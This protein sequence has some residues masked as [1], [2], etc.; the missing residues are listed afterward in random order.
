MLSSARLL[1]A[2]GTGAIRPL[3]DKG[4]TGRREKVCALRARMSTFGQVIGLSSGGSRLR[5]ISYVAKR[6]YDANSLI[7]GNRR[8]HF[9]SAFVSACSIRLSSQ[10]RETAISLTSR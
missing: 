9:V 6:A 4:I 3:G 5:A 8:L 1:F 10:L 7:S 2:G